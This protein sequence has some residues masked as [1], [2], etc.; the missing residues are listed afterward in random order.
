VANKRKTLV[1]S[2]LSIEELEAELK[3]RKQAVSADDMTEEIKEEK[4]PLDELIPVISL[5]DYP[6]NLSTLG[7]GQGKNVRFEKFAQRKQILYQ[8]LLSIMEAYR[9]FMEN[10][11]FYILD[12]RVIRAHG[13]Q[14]TYSKILTKEKIES[15]LAGSKEAVELYKNCNPEQQ[16]IV[17]G[18][19][20][21]LVRDDPNSVDL[22]MIDQLSR[23]S[24]IDI[25]KKADDARELMTPLKEEEEK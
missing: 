14:E 21:G 8:D 4:I 11:L 17:I 10:G 23:Q 20:V 3:R 24:G 9:S 18:M 19:L 13:L 16:K 15:I 7:N 6:L 2:T 12:K 1:Q 25:K 22:N 5:I